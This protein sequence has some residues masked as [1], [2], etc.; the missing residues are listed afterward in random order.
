MVKVPPCCEDSAHLTNKQEHTYLYWPATEVDR[1]MKVHY[2]SRCGISDNSDTSDSRQ[3]Q[4]CLKD[5]V[6]V[7]ISNKAL[8]RTRWAMGICRVGPCF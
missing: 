8:F 5:I 4:K 3:E 1:S 2:I 6:T 7:Y